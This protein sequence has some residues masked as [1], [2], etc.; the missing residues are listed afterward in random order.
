MKDC[1]ISGEVVY[2]NCGCYFGVDVFWQ[3][4]EVVWGEA[5]LLLENTA[6]YV[7]ANNSLAYLKKDLGTI[8]FYFWRIAF[9]LF[10]LYF[11]FVLCRIALTNN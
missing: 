11:I 2:E 6:V 4:E 5:S 8:N 1:E 3:G 10:F 7:V 9:L